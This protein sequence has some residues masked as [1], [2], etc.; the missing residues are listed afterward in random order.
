MA[1]ADAHVAAECARRGVPFHAADAYIALLVAHADAPD[2]A[3]VDRILPLRDADQSLDVLARRLITGRGVEKDLIEARSLLLVKGAVPGAK[4]GH[5]V[6][7][8]AIKAKAK[9]GAQ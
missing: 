4:N 2:G 9:K 6:V 5:V 1:P 8:P 3:K 7:R